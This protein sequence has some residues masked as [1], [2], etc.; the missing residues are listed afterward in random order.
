VGTKKKAGRTVPN[1]VPGNTDEAANPAQQAAIAINMKKHHQTPKK[2]NEFAPDDGGGDGGEED[3]LHKYARMWYNGDLGTQQKVEQILDRMGWEIGEIESEEGGCFVVQAGDEDGKS[4][5]GFAPEDL[6]EG[7]LNEFAP[8]EGGGSRKF[9]PWPEFIEQVK[10]I[11]GK[12]FDC[13]ENVVKSTIKARFVPHDPMEY[14][15]TMLYSYYETRAGGRNKGAVSTRGSIQVGKYTKGGLFGQ[16]PDQLL[17]GFHLLKGH[18]FERHFDLT[19]DNIYKIAN[20]ILGNTEGALEFKPEGVAEGHDDDGYGYKSFTA[21]D[22]MKLINTGNWEA[23]ADITPGRHLQ[24]RNT[25][26]G[27]TTTVH[28]KQSMT[29]DPDALFDMIEEMVE[30]IAQQHG[31]DAEFIW[32]YLEPVSDQELLETAAWKRKAGKNK[33]GGLNRKG[34][35]SYRR[36]HPGSK[37]Q[38]AVTTKPSKLKPGSKAAKRRKSFCARMSGM[39]G[40][41]KKP[42]G[43]PTR[44]ALALRKWNC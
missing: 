43:K 37:L 29:E 39:K 16:A 42:N 14:G 44:K 11:V 19:F 26:N 6:S 1:C 24:L 9:I 23:M 36:E 28:V 34:V 4:Y 33:N 21:E 10:Q 35:M 41:M 17:T 18:P 5:I 8:D 38:T 12:D 15:P 31:V 40:A 7:S 25:R 30:H 13:K 32:E 27:K 22:I 3:T 2:M 20:I